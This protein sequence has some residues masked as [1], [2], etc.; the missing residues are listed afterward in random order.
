MVQVHSFNTR[1]T[2]LRIVQPLTVL[3]GDSPGMREILTPWL[4]QLLAANGLHS[5]AP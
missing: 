4:W 1:S 3:G 5:H 2:S